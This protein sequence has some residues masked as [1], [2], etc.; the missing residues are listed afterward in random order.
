MLCALGTV[1]WFKAS[2][3]SVDV[4]VIRQTV[5]R[6]STVTALDLTTASV[7]Q[8]PGV[9][10][11][12]AD[13]L[14]SE[15]GM[16]ARYDLVA[17]S[18][19]NAAA[20]TSNP[21]PAKGHVQ[22]GLRLQ[23]GQIPSEPLTPGNPLL[24]V[25]APTTQDNQDNGSTGQTTSGGTTTEGGTTAS[26]TPGTTTASG[27]AQ[28]WPAVLVSLQAQPDGTSTLMTVD[29][30]G[31]NAPVIAHAAAAGNIAVVRLSSQR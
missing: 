28:N 31:T 6:G 29:V 24:L 3:K 9:S 1:Y 15:V 13:Q 21:Q 10:T 12:P 4:V 25:Y 22:I 14:A 26:G 30:V 7:G 16:I 20:L 18:P 11:V 19:L 23:P 8:L 5:P 17:G 27:S 2:A